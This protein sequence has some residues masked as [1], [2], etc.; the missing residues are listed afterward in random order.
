MFD[1]TK[2]PLYDEDMN[3]IEDHYFN[4]EDADDIEEGDEK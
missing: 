1:E 3:L 2:L 4:P